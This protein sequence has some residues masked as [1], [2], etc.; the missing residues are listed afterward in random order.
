MKL[1][2]GIDVPDSVWPCV[3]LCS[4]ESMKSGILDALSRSARMSRVVRLTSD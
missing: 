2:F 4:I 3:T 1:S